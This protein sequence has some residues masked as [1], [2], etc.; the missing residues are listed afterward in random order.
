MEIWALMDM[1]M[2]WLHSE[3]VLVCTAD[4]DIFAT[5]ASEILDE[6]EAPPFAMYRN[7]LGDA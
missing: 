6:N 1:R 4:R 2:E 5:A 3:G 7:R